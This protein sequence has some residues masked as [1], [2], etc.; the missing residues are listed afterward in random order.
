ML[1]WTYR[2]KKH[3]VRPGGFTLIEL[4]VVISIIALLMAMLAPALRT[5]RAQAK[6]VVCGV[7]LKQWGVA[8]SC[9][10][11]EYG[12]VWPHSDGL[13]R[14]PDDINDPDISQED[15]ADWHGWVDVLPPMINLKPWRQFPDN[16]HPGQSTFYQCPTAELS[17]PTSL[18]SYYPERDGY[19]SYAM[20]AC[21][22]LDENAWEPPDGVGYPMPSFL[23]TTRI[24]CPQ[25]VVLLFDQLLDVRKGYDGT[26]PYRSAGQHCG[27][28][29]IAFSA[30]HV[31]SRSKLGGNILFCDGHVGWQKTVWA[32]EWGDWQ[33]GRQQSPPRSDPNWYPYPGPRSSAE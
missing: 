8:F 5:A 18:Y 6:Q 21:L 17:E 10:S 28:Y 7:R 11:A 32:E 24:V 20:N 27:G 30:R 23:D 15:L 4:L 33:I 9:Y 14:G 12:A 2:R 31:R 13:D 26:A 1:H 19:F 29:P 16:E 3:V 22:E 25:R